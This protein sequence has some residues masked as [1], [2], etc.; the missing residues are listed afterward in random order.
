[1]IKVVM[2]PVAW[3]MSQ[4]EVYVSQAKGELER[5]KAE[6]MEEKESQEQEL[7]SLLNDGYQMLACQTV[8]AARRTILTFVLHKPAATS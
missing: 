3:E 5:L 2:V 4:E 1:M 7:D 8:T 6:R